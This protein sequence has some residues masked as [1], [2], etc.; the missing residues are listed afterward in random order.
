MTHAG[1]VRARLGPLLSSA[2]RSPVTARLTG[3]VAAAAIAL[4]AGPSAASPWTLGRG[5]AYGYAGVFWTRSQYFYDA[6]GDRQQFI[7]DGTSQVRGVELQGAHGLA[8]RWMVSAQLPFLWYELEDELVR[9][10]GRSPGDLRLGL[11]WWALTSPLDAAL[12]GGVKLPTAKRRDPSRARVGEGQTDLE[13]LASVGRSS[14]SIGAWASVDAG[15]RWRRRDGETGLKPGDEWLYR[16]E[17]GYQ[18]SGSLTATTQLVGFDGGT[19]QARGFGL[20]VPAATERRGRQPESRPGLPAGSRLAA[21]A[22]GEPA[23][24][25]SAVLRRPPVRPRPGL[26][27]LGADPRAG[28]VD[29]PADP[30]QPPEPAGFLVLPDPVTSRAQVGS[31]GQPAHSEGDGKMVEGEVR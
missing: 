20:T 4:S 22:V 29:P 24:R 15:F 3:A 19:G 27:T 12:Q 16:L 2:P 11:R 9:D 6:S 28:R 31:T 18:V 23:S 7:R 13:L 8:D 26:R 30:R 1:D 17:L 21:G 10:A 25:R 5:E 14:R